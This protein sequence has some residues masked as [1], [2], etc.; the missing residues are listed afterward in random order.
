MNKICKYNDNNKQ[1][2]GKIEKTFQIKIAVNY[3]CNTRLCGSI[4]V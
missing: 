3:L 2:F 4:A 1:H